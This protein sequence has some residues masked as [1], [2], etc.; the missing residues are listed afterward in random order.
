MM[1]AVRNQKD[2]EYQLEAKDLNRLG[3]LR[4]SLGKWRK[5]VVYTAASM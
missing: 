4:S 5:K 2:I 1:I 3:L